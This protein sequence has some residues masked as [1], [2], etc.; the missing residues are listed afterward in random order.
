MPYQDDDESVETSEPVELYDFVVDTV[1]YRYTSGAVAFEYE[2]EDYTPIAIE[3]EAVVVSSGGMDELTV[4]IPTSCTF[5]QDIAF[6]VPPQNMYL[7]IYRYQPNSATAV[8]LWSGRI[9][10]LTVQGPVTMVRSPSIVDDALRT[11][12]PSVV[13]QALCNHTL[14]DA[15]CGIERGDFDLVT[16]ANT[17]NGLEIV[18][19]SVGAAIDNFYRAGEIWI[20]N[21]K[22]T[23]ITQV[24][25]T[26]TLLWPF[27]VSIEDP[28]ACTIYAGC[29]HTVKTC[30]DKFAN[31]ENFGG[32]P[33]L[34]WKN[35]FENG[36]L[37][38]G[39]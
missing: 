18:V 16:T 34:K 19:A 10:P 2:S 8:I 29:D 14:F 33:F 13:A 4:T 31:V 38:G 30:R 12:I 6:D 9:M 39:D 1:T 28:V 35:P 32:Y 20:G 24:G 15:N 36:H 25:T 3:R 5:V 37:W 23:I 21:Q 26:L 22:R 27:P 11:Q 17:I 7:T